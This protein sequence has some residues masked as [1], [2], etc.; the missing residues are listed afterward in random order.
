MLLN[1]TRNESAEHLWQEYLS[2][3]DDPDAAERWF[4]EVFRIG[5]TP[6]GADHGADLILR[7]VKTATSEL[8]WV[9]QADAIPQPT[10]GSLSIVEKGDGE[11]VCVV[12]TTEVRAVAFRDVDAKFA[13][14][15]GEWNRSLK[16]WRLECWQHFVAACERMGREP[17]HDM[18]LV[19]ER[20][21]VV[22]PDLS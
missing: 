12:R 6:E 11:A 5:S 8:L 20:F 14:D 15:Y 21:R 22:W 19:C 9:Y 7:G 1:T 4:Y 18:P 3:L 10:K 17:T 2:S 16:T 13:Y